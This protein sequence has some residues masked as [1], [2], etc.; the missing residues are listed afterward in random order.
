MIKIYGETFA[1][2]SSDFQAKFKLQIPLLNAF[3]INQCQN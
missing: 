1:D 3:E 2:H